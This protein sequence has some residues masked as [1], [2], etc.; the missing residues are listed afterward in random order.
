[1][2]TSLNLILDTSGDALGFSVVTQQGACL[3]QA[4]AHLNQRQQ[5]S[6]ALPH[7]LQQ[8]LALLQPPHHRLAHVWVN[9]GPGSFTGL[10]A[11]LVLARTLGQFWSESP[12]GNTPPPQFHAFTTFQRLV[13]QAQQA[14]AL[15]CHTPCVPVALDARLGKSY[16]ATLS[17][18][19]AGG[20]QLQ[21]PAAWLPV[22][23]LEA[24]L[25]PLDACITSPS[26]RGDGLRAPNSLC[27]EAL[28][29]YFAEALACIAQW[30]DP[31][32]LA[33]W[34]QLEPLYLQGPNISVSKKTK[35]AAT[36]LP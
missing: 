32:P 2:S 5:H 29:P 4:A 17:Q 26:L 34:Q 22:A 15:P 14:Q 9:V 30:E 16:C 3:L 13:V 7:Y 20:W 12:W 18:D 35:A 10:R 11:S 36:N 25:K 23:Q 6:A 33:S 21:A 28:A 24:L 31:H 27:T 8:L 19:K 1:M